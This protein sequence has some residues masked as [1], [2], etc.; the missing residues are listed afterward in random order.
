MCFI[1][2]RRFSLRTIIHRM[3]FLFFQKNISKEIQNAFI[4][5]FEKTLLFETFVL[6]EKETFDVD[7]K[8]RET[9]VSL[10]SFHREVWMWNRVSLFQ[11][12]IRPERKR[13]MLINEEIFNKIFTSRCFGSCKNTS[14]KPERGR[15][16]GRAILE[17]ENYCNGRK[18][19]SA[20]KQNNKWCVN[21]RKS[22]NEKFSLLSIGQ[23]TSI[24]RGQAISF[25]HFHFYLKINSNW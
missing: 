5:S 13:K 8:K 18:G 19:N 7:E 15:R 17:D 2:H 4:R 20:T 1:N 25:H 16:T 9:F 12:L 21:S 22:T 3:I 24:D 6:K 23:I 10:L 11:L 14:G